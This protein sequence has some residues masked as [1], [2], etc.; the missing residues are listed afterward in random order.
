MNPIDPAHSAV[1]AMHLQGD[2]VGPDGALAPFFQ[3]EIQRTGVLGTISS[4]LDGARASG[5]KVVYARVAFRPDFSDMVPN[6]PLLAMTAE[7]NCLV[8]GTPA[9]EIMTDLAPHAGEIIVTHQRVSAFHASSLDVLLRGAG[10]DTVI[11]AGGATNLSVEGTA[12]TASGLGYRT[13]VVSDGCSA[14]S[15]AA[16]SASLASL[17]LLAEI[18]A[19]D[20]LLTAVRTPAT[21]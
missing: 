18:A 15:E 8:D 12:R 20:E 6:C 11:I 1:I 9:A 17:G 3:A 21:L 4:L 19:T 16:H 5:V 10:I 2:I 13:I 14:G 7:S